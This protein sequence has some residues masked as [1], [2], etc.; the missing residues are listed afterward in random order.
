[1]RRLHVSI[2]KTEVERIGDG[3]TIKVLTNEHKLLHSVTVT[4]IPVGLKGRVLL[5]KVAQL[6]SRHR[7][8]PHARTLQTLL[9]ACLLKEEA[10][11]RIILKPAQALA[12]Y[13]TFWPFACHEIVKIVHVERTATAIDKRANAIFFNLATLMVVMMMV[14][15]TTKVVVFMLVFMLMF[16]L[17]FVLMLVLVLML[18]F[19]LVLVLVFMLMLMLVL[20][21][22]LMLVLIML[23]MRFLQLFYPCCRCGHL[24]KNK[25]MGVEQTLEVYVSIVARDN[26][27]FR[28][29]SANDLAHM[30]Q[31]VSAHLRCFVQQD[32]VAKLYLLNDEVLNVLL[33]N[34]FLCESIAALKLVA[35]AKG[36]NNR[37]DTVETR[38][39]VFYILRTERR[40]R[41]DGLCYRCRL[42]D[43]ARLDND[44]IET[45]HG[46]D[47]VK[48]LHKIHLQCAADTS[49]LQS[50][51]AIVLLV[52]DATLLNE[53]CI[54]INLSY[55]VHNDGKLNAFLVCENAVEQCR[56]DASN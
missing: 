54:D 30:Q 23:L 33:I 49:V 1:M 26:L 56:A 29:D 9:I 51:K 22:V 27:C 45:F 7:G 5:L 10:I 42:T 25:L 15:M 6:V 16:V 13:D 40:E 19:V 48:L 52:H 4:L 32:G 34:I 39:A 12:T 24:V 53:V 20:V 37:H 43:A 38:H 21:F 14:V 18:V 3:L 50:H 47:I 55:V 46:N 17:V 44:I 41:A 28:L 35:H 31:F 36:V 11:V 2:G 8:I